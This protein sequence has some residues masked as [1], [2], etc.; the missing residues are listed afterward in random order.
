M[1]GG[2]VGC[3]R[4]FNRRVRSKGKSLDDSD[5]DYVI[6]DEENKVLDGWEEE[7]EE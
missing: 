5:G 4:N 6:S 2:K 1:R 3:K 7:D